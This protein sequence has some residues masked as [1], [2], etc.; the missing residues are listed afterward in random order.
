M[1]AD[2]AG[3]AEL[4]G[5][6]SAT[7]ATAA[8]AIPVGEPHPPLATDT[9]SAGAAVRLNAGGGIL[10]GNAE[11]HV[12]DLGELAARLAM[13]SGAFS[14]QEAA[15]AAAQ[16]AVVTGP[17]RGDTQQLQQLPPPLVRPPVAA[18]VR[19]PLA[20]T[21]PPGGEALAAQYAAGSATA[22]SGF[23]QGWRA[24]AAA[25][26]E[27]ASDLRAAAAWLPE[28]W[29]T[30][31]PG[32]AIAAVFT[33][34]AA[35]FDNLADQADKLS[36]QAASHGDNFDTATRS[37]PTPAEFAT[38][39]QNLRTAQMN[40]ARQP[41]LWATQV[42]EL[43]AERSRLEQRALNAHATYLADSTK[44]TDPYNGTGE[45]PDNPGTGGEQPGDPSAP[46][47]QGDVNSAGIDPVTGLPTDALTSPDG[48]GLDDPMLSQMMPML[49]STLVGGVGGL[50]GSLVQPL[51][52]FPQQVLSAGSSALQ[53]ATQ[54]ASAAGKG[55][56]PPEIPDIKPEGLPD[57]G[58]GGGGAGG[59]ETAPAAG[60]DGMPAVAG[61]GPM[62]A[63][64]APPVAASGSIPTTATSGTSGAMGG[65]MAP[66]M[67]PPMGGAPGGGG[68]DKD[69]KQETR[70]ALHERPNSEP[71]SGEVQQRVEAVAAGTERVPPPEPRRSNVFRITEPES[72]TP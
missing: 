56:D 14:A 40:N 5:R 23:T 70:I 17:R 39:R 28:V 42:A 33:T 1:K 18:D 58:S 22:G 60:L 41:G 25:L 12:A 32:A 50:L 46:D 59:G 67:M 52:S 53:G 15:N 57:I 51:S 62:T 6:L 55:F 72:D 48:S 7:A 37:A 68:Q 35:T 29:R 10:V 61:A 4:A 13:I 20:P 36:A 24:A 43:T 71:V 34:R 30:T 65:G 31:A 19:P 38:N 3:L 2:P 26:R 27:A 9:V 16:A 11:S 49:F 8:A 54:A 21:L 66:P 45:D 47:G 64:A 63:P 44:D 69:K